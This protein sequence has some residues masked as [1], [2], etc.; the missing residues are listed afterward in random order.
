[1][2]KASQLYTTKKKNFLKTVPLQM[3]LF[4]VLQ[5]VPEVIISVLQKY[6][7]CWQL[8]HQMLQITKYRH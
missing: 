2:V 3:C 7:K 1:M 6:M 4:A 8:L 5:E